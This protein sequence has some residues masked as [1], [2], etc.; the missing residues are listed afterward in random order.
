M[1]KDKSDNEALSTIKKASEEICLDLSDAKVRRTSSR[2]CLS[3]EHGDYNGTNL[4]GVGVNRFLWFAYKASENKQSKLYSL[5]F[6]EEGVCNFSIDRIPYPFSPK[7]KDKWLRFLLGVIYILRKNGFNITKGIEGILYSNIPGGGMSRSAS[8]T[9]NLII[10][11]LDVNNIEIKELFKIIKMAQAVENDYI[12][13]PCGNLDQTMILFA[14][15]G[16]GTHFNPYSNAIEYIDLPPNTPDFRFVILDTG[17]ERPGL[18]KSAYKIRRNECE[19][20]LSILQKE[21]FN[22]QSL[23]DIDKN[24]Y[25]KIK[26]ECSYLN[27]NYF[28]RLKYIFE[29]KERFSEMLASWKNGDIENV[30][31]LFRLDGIGLRDNY[32]ISGPELDTMCGIVHGIPGVLGERLL[33]GGEKGAACAI[34]LSDSIEKVKR[35]IAEKYPKKHPEYASKYQVYALNIVDGMKLM[36]N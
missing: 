18:E 30:G 32:Q 9:L 34:V 29:A 19:A 26:S 2:L 22:I 7:V 13:S 21:G 6:P 20:L 3:V 31:R 16:K 5:N 35:T 1:I 4:F 12:G 8:L 33:G 25:E 23:A 10:S 36:L 17:T 24:M 14:K 11:L 27:A 15:A 28:K